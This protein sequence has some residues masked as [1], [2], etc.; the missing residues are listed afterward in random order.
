MLL[1]TLKILGFVFPT[2]PLLAFA[3][4]QFQTTEQEG[5]RNLFRGPFCPSFSALPVI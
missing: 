3:E 2:S 1:V 5:C 4:I